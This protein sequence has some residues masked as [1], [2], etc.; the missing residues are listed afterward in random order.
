MSISNDIILTCDD[1]NRRAGFKRLFAIDQ[2]QITDFTAGALQ[3]Y[4]AV[5]VVTAATDFFQEIQFDE[6]GCSYAGESSKEN[7]S[8]TIEHTVEAVIPKM[9]KVKGL[10]IQELFT[11]CRLI[12][13]AETFISTGSFNQAFVIGFDEILGS[14]AALT[15]A[16]N[17]AIEAEL[18]GQNAYTVSMKGMGAEVIREFVGA[19]PTSALG[20][21]TE[22]FGS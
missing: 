14:T 6:F 19:I 11:S 12:L 20:A 1:E 8:S 13:V 18:A 3:D 10:V 7:G 22:D 21:T 15:A 2:T 17:G 16:V 5:T 4:N 9:E